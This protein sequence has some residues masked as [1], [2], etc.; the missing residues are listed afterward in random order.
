MDQ[1]YLNKSKTKTIVFI[2]GFYANAGY[3]LPYLTNFKNYRIVLLNI[4]YNDLLNSDN[5]IVA[6]NSL[7]RNVN[8]GNNFYALI[9]HSLGTVVSNFIGADLVNKRFE[10]C[11]VGY[12]KR[13][14]TAG[15]VSD[16]RS[17]VNQGEQEII[18]RLLLVD[19][20]INESKIYF[21]NNSI[22]YLPDADQYF[23]YTD[24]TNN[25]ISFKGDHFDINE[26]IVDIANRLKQ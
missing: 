17:R 19:R 4:N 25:R 21:Q 10:I 16:I 13:S 5:M 8:S 2:H 26:A 12:S 23:T 1:I 11:P 9:S 15:F 3:W 6:S 14:D 22:Q 18:T 20:L 7:L 24:L